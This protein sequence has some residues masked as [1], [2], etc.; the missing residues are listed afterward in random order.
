MRCGSSFGCGQHRESFT[1]ALCAAEVPPMRAARLRVPYRG[2][3]STVISRH[4]LNAPDLAS[5]SAARNCSRA[6]GRLRPHSGQRDVL[7]ASMR[8]IF[9]MN[10]WRHPEH[11]SG[12][13]SSSP[14]MGELSDA[15]SIAHQDR[16]NGRPSILSPSELPSAERRLVGGRADRE[17][18]RDDR[19][20][21]FKLIRIAQNGHLFARRLAKRRFRALH[22]ALRRR[23]HHC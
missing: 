21:R 3:S 20:A 18:R 19:R 12:Q 7:S 8:S 1:D 6:R 16:S 11:L 13:W 23:R 5:A 10:S 15:S 22:A 14:Y 9:S 2:I 4:G 17:L